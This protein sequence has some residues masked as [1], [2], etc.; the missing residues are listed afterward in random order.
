MNSLSL[1]YPELQNKPTTLQTVTKQPYKYVTTQST[2]PN[3]SICSN[4]RELAIREVD[5]RNSM[6]SVQH[7]KKICYLKRK[8][9]KKNA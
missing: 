4:N 5:M 2:S 7:T 6:G 8:E 1:C 9:R 3:S